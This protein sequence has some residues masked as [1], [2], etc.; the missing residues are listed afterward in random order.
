MIHALLLA[1]V[2]LS[3]PITAEEV[4]RGVASAPEVRQALDRE[5]N[6]YPSARFREVFITVN[7][8]ADGRRGPYF[9]GKVNAKNRMGAYVGWTDFVASDVGIVDVRGDGD[10]F[11]LDTLCGA[12]DPRD[13]TDRSALLAHR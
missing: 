6:D 8:Q 7:G 1:G 9:C 5:L 2:V 4:R 11:L 13:S 12:D 3:D 10:D